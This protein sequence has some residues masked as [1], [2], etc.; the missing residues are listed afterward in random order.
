MVAPKFEYITE[1][2]YRL[3]IPFECIYTTVFALVDKK[4]AILL[5]CGSC[6]ADVDNYLLPALCREGWEMCGMLCSHRHEDHDG[7]LGRMTELFP[8]K[9]LKPIEGDILLSRFHVIALPGHTADCIG[10]WDPQ[11]RT[12]IACDA[13]QQKSIDRFPI[14]VSDPDAYKQTLERIRTLAPQ[15]LLCSH[16]YD[17]FGWCITGTDIEKC[18]AFSERAVFAS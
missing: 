9:I 8:G 5:D 12:V 18:L 3:C 1:G 7:G 11:T 14:S 2:I 17:P 4:R 13:V 15:M 16:D 10:I 6:D